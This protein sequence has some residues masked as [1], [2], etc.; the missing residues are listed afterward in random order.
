MDIQGQR[1]PDV[2]GGQR[3][4]DLT[5]FNNRFHGAKLLEVVKGAETIHH[6]KENARVAETIALKRLFGEQGINVRSAATPGQYSA[7]HET[8]D[9]GTRS[10]YGG[11]A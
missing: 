1:Q 11:L 6:A 4:R 10:R 3:R 5:Q 2:S 8:S 9:S 7:D